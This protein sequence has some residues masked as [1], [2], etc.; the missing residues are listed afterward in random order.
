LIIEFERKEDKIHF[1]K[2]KTLNGQEWILALE[3]PQQ[4]RLTLRG[5]ERAHQQNHIKAKHEQ[6]K[7]SKT[8]P[9]T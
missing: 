8:Y 7:L 6:L 9:S 4:E 2:A 5:R 1:A 3:M